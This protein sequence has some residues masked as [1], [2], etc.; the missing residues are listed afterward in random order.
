MTEP[1]SRHAAARVTNSSARHHLCVWLVFLC[2]GGAGPSVGP[3]KRQR[4]KAARAAHTHTHTRIIHVGSEGDVEHRAAFQVHSRRRRRPSRPSET[5]GRL[6][7]VCRLSAGRLVG[8][9]VQKLGNSPVTS[10]AP[11]NA[12]TCSSPQ[13]EH[14]DG[15]RGGLA[16]S[17]SCFSA[18]P[19]NT[20]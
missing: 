10:L 16:A 9:L 1:Q 6:Q 11:V 17:G 13:P 2:W 15:Q 20:R 7:V 12:T 14:G 19:L 3:R 18:V 8:A 5:A 4:G